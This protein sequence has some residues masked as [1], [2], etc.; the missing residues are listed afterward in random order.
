[1]IE[2]IYCFEVKYQ[3]LQDT[4][5]TFTGFAI[6][7]YNFEKTLYG[8]NKAFIIKDL[9]DDYNINRLYK[10]KPREFNPIKLEFNKVLTYYNHFVEAVRI[11]NLSKPKYCVPKYMQQCHKYKTYYENIVELLQLVIAKWDDWN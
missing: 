5:N 8:V 6:N 10:F 11:S 4:T 1:M 7:D 9:I 3:V 2:P